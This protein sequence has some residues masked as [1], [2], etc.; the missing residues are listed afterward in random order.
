MYTESVREE[1]E[2][3]LQKNPKYQEMLF[4]RGY[5]FTS[6]KIEDLEGFP[7]YANWNSEILNNYHLYVHEKQ[8][9]YHLAKG[10]RHVVIIG[11]AYNPFDM[12]YKEKL[13]CKDLLE[14][15]ETGLDTYFEKISEFTGLHVIVLVDDKRVIFCQDACSLT[16][17]YFGIVDGAMYVSEQ[18]QLIADICHLEMDQTIRKLVESRCYNIGNRHLPGNLTPYKKV[19]RLG[20]NTYLNFEDRFSV[21]RFFPIH[22]HD[23]YKSDEEIQNAIERIAQLLH[24][25]IECCTKK[26]E[27]CTISLSGGTDSKTTLAC[28]KGL[29]DKFSYYSFYSKP[30]ELVDANAASEICAKLGLKHTLY[31]IPQ[32][33]DSFEA[34]DLIKKILKHSTSYF[35]NLADSEIR[36]YIYLHDLDAYDIELKSWASEVPRVFLERKYQLKMPKVLT[37]RHCSVFQ[38][39]YFM[40][41][42]LLRWSDKTYYRFLRS[43]H[44]E[45]P[46][47]NYEHSD[48]FYWEIRMGCWG[49]TVISS[50][51]IYHRTTIPM[52]NRKILDLFLCIPR[53]LRIDDTAHKM[54]MEHS[55]PDVVNADVEVKNL[56]FHSYRIWMEKLYYLYRTMFY[57]PKK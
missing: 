47:F 17:C 36:K 23:E 8:T 52:N 55:N 12:T 5:L 49:V 37:E 1:L 48:L 15:Y 25:G 56:Y 27:R 24:N 42:M 41:P 16:G 3:E 2:R 50:Q 28:A 53:E 44:L 4:R 22:P 21:R 46:L 45:K 6:R 43:I 7:F 13:L 51:Q 34:F 20:A 10:N 35:I 39:R 29:Y 33:N 57:V 31:T 38:T 19:R 9:Y 14:A 40:H 30:Q 26:W 32:D 18:S 11:H 54:V